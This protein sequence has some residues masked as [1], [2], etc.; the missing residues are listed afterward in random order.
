[1]I[2]SIKSSIGTAGAGL[3]LVGAAMLPVAA[4]AQGE[5][6]AAPVDSVSSLIV[7]RDAATGQLR[8]P[9]AAEARALQPEAVRRSNHLGTLPRVHPSGAQG[10]RLTDAMMSYSVVVRQPDGSL[11]EQCFDSRDVAESALKAAP[12][13]RNPAAPTE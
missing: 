5:S 11:T 10:A 13:A 7:V 9:T 1:M 8:A 12:V 6:A 4:F 3:A 2:A